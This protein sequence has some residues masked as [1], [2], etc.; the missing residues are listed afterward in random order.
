MA[1]GR[2]RLIDD[3]LDRRPSNLHGCASAERWQP[4]RAGVGR[5]LA[6]VVTLNNDANHSD[7]AMWLEYLSSLDWAGLGRTT[8]SMRSLGAGP[9]KWRADSEASLRASLS[10]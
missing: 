10:G 3:V 7:A 4:R 5:R 9:S 6:G 8:S 2:L 1:R